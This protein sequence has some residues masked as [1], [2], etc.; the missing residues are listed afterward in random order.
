MFVEICDAECP[1][2]INTVGI[3]ERNY[4]ATQLKCRHK[5]SDDYDNVDHDHDCDDDPITDEA[6]FSCCIYLPCMGVKLCLSNYEKKTT[7]TS[8]QNLDIR[9]EVIVGLRNFKMGGG[10]S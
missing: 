8:E 1:D 3:S 6:T 2:L 10:A 5:Y 9:E 7:R 4:S